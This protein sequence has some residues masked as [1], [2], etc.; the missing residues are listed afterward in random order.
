VLD[1]VAERVY[2]IEVEGANGHQE[3][4]K[5]NKDSRASSAGV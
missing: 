4:N 5:K 3:Y 2:G 1:D